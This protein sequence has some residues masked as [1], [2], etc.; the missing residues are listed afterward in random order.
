MNLTELEETVLAHFLSVEA[1]RVSVD[2]RYY[3]REDFVQI[4]QDRIFF[5]SQQ[6]VG[7]GVEQ[8]SNI[9]SL[10]V[11]KLIEEKGLSTVND[12]WTGVSHQFAPARYK[13]VINELIESNAICQRA[14]EGGSQFWQDVFAKL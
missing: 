6:L 9:A 12:K 13:I 14:R 2:G 5:A 4:F 1:A 7:G 10:L 3:R 11:D 8:H